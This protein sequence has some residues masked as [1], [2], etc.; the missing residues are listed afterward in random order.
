M[1]TVFSPLVMYYKPMNY[2]RGVTM[3]DYSKARV[4]YGDGLNY[5]RCSRYSLDGMF[6]K[7]D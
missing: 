7:G 6:F 2:H 5:A 1:F 4:G 3:Y